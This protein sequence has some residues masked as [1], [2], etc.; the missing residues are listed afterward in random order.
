MKIITIAI[1]ISISIIMLAKSG[2]YF[3]SAICLHIYVDF[4]CFKLTSHF[5]LAMF[6][7]F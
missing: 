5:V 3:K 7:Y 6:F 1:T 2:Y 4:Y